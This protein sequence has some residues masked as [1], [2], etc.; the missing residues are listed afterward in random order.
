MTG[1]LLLVAA[2]LLS[3]FGQLCQKQAALVPPGPGKYPRIVL[4][5]GAALVMLG[6]SMIAWLGVLHRIPVGV[7][8]PLLSLNI[9]WVTLASRLVWKEPVS[10][11]HWLGIGLIL[12]GGIWVGGGI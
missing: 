3:C 2:S 4:W 8:Y 11:R 9:V 5:L 7:A 12:L 1:V 6:C 10:A